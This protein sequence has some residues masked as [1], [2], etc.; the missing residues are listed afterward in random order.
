MLKRLLQ[1]EN[2]WSGAV[3]MKVGEVEV[4]VVERC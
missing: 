4:G 1:K 3:R 2:H